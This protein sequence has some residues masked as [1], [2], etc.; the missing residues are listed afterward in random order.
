[1]IAFIVELLSMRPLLLALLNP[2]G[3]THP[4]SCG[5]TVQADKQVH[6]IMPS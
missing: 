1:M 4:S 3:C 2:Y 5:G 6:Q